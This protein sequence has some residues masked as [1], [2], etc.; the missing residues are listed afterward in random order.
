MQQSVLGGTLEIFF[1]IYII[2][3]EPRHYAYIV[4]II[5]TTTRRC[6]ATAEIAREAYVEPTV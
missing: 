6:S 1:K 2:L 5:I 3:L 4:I